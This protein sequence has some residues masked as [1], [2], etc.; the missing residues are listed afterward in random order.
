MPSLKNSHFAEGIREI[1]QIP[2]EFA[3]SGHSCVLHPL[4]N[5]CIIRMDAGLCAELR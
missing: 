3:Y 4:F 1:L 2:C 5:R